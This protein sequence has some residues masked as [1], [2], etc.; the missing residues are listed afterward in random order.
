MNK[1]KVIN[2]LLKARTQTYAGN[3]S[4]VEPL[5][6]GSTQFEYSKD[7]LLYRDIYNIGNG[8]FVGLE[9][10]YLNDAPIWSMSYFG[11][12]KKMSEEETD[13]ILRK[14]LIDK[15]NKA[16]LWDDIKVKSDGYEYICEGSGDISEFG[17]TEKIV[18]KNETVYYFYYAA[19]FISEL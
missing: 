11:N 4:K 18:K 16:R 14:A 15:W 9:T 7:T 10:I 17:G 8:L 3:D 13:K 12:F 5:L 1:Q 2:F 19:G 6:K